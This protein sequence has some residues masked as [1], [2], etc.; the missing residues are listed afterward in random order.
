MSFNPDFNTFIE[1]LSALDDSIS[2][3]DNP[4]S[5]STEVSGQTGDHSATD[6]PTQDPL[7]SVEPGPDVNQPSSHSVQQTIPVTEDDLTPTLPNEW[8]GLKG[9]IDDQL[10]PSSKG[11]S[12]RDQIPDGPEDPKSQG[13]KPL[14]DVVENNRAGTPSAVLIDQKSRDKVKK[15][16]SPQEAIPFPHSAEFFEYS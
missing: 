10:D 15:V 9:W 6:S 13:P 16:K 4:P 11:D 5:P 7:G 3:K 14:L 2:G 1:T 8:E 12:G